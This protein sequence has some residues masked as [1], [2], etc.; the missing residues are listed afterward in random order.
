MNGSPRGDGNTASSPGVFASYPPLLGLRARSSPAC[1][2]NT[3][4]A[5][6]T[7]RNPSC[8]R[9]NTR[10]VLGAL[11]N[12]TCA[13]REHPS[14]AR[15]TSELCV[16]PPGTP[17]SG[18]RCRWDSGISGQALERFGSVRNAAEQFRRRPINSDWPRR[19]AGSGRGRRHFRR[20]TE[21]RVRGG[22]KMAAP[23]ERELTAEQTEKLLQFQ[24]P[25][26]GG[27]CW[28]AGAGEAVH[29]HGMG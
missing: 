7:P 9:G 4:A 25:R 6:G 3:R 10:A 16:C 26:P 23:E 8:V 13:R 21:R 18:H 22:S 17:E 29:G 1:S 14:S 24:V 11:R 19:W 20:V 27:P 28:P 15:H 2:G 12:F 5:L